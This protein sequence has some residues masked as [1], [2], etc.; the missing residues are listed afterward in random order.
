MNTKEIKEYKKRLHLTRELREILV[1]ILLGDAH[2]ETQNNGRTYRLKIEQ[3]LTHK[4][5]VDHLY[6]KFR[7]WVLTPPKIRDV[8]TKGVLSRNYRFTTLDHGSLRFY[9]QQFY[10]NGKKCVPKIINRLLTARGLAYWFMDDGSIKSKESKG[11]IFNTQSFSKKEIQMLI[12]VLNNKFGLKAKIRPQKNRY[13][14]YVSGESYEKFVD[15]VKPYL[16]KEMEYK[17]PQERRT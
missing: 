16:L 2:L 3:A 4:E 8:I 11:L 13:Q 12:S 6:E 10:K 15:I 17:L 5:Y 14:I 1:G 7:L 9:G